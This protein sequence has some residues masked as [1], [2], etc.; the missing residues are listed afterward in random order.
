MTSIVSALAASLY[1][2]QFRRLDL[3]IL[4]IGMFAAIMV[5][6]SLA[7]RL[8]FRDFGSALVLAILLIGLVAGAA[9]WLREISRRWE[10]SA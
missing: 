10:H 1:Y 5:I 8:M 7:V 6:M 3:F 9:Y 4:T 2:Y